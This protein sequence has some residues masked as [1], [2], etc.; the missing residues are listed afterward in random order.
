MEYEEFLKSKTRTAPNCGFSVERSEI[1]PKLFEWQKDIVIWALKKGRAGLF[2]DCGLGKTLQQLEWSDKIVKHCN[3]PV[4][5]VAPLAVAE[6]T[7][8]EGLKFGYT[9]NICRTQN[10]VKS[11][12][13][14]TNYE[15]LDHFD[16]DTF[17]GVVLD[18]SS[19]LKNFTGK[20]RTQI[21]DMF[22]KTPYKLSC[23]ATP[24]PNDFM[25]LGNQAEFLGVMNRT[26]ML[27]TYFTHDG[28]ETSKWRLKGHAEE[29]F[30][31]W[32]ATFAVVIGSPSDLGYESEGYDLPELNIKEVQVDIT[33]D[34]VA[35]GENV[36]LF[37]RAA[38]T[39]SE[40]RSARKNSM[41]ERCNAA[42]KLC[43]S[44]PDEQWLIWCDLNAESE[45]LSDIIQD[46]VEIRGSN[47]IEEKT[48]ALNGFSD[49]KVKRLITKPSIAGFGLNWQKCHNMIFVGVSDSYEMM[50]QA[51]RRCF[52]FGQEQTVNV[53]LVTSEAEQNVLENVKRKEKQCEFMK[54]KMI[55]H[56]KDILMEEIRGTVR[57]EIPYNP[58]IKMILPEWL[59]EST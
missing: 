37:A 28:G 41:I 25:E 46:S 24:A 21:I 3:Q 38:E 51:I 48:D 12:I 43:E 2:E 22:F 1:N 55:K 26:E 16:G 6:Q 32:L 15:M 17:C 57:I 45:L 39:L 59:E 34:D 40:R 49:G 44:S 56:T 4:L 19:I 36:S 27:A 7:K 30:W 13:N 29:K 58:R 42:L 52:R 54:Q 31:A 50:Y 5:I 11:G 8:R 10:D 20:V 9:V 35:V 33:P 23:T 14:I 47:T 53:Y 18:E